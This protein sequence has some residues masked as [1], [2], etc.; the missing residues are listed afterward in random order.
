[1]AEE[2]AAGGQPVEGRSGGPCALGVC[3]PACGSR[4]AGRLE[5]IMRCLQKSC[6]QAIAAALVCLL[7]GT[8]QAQVSTATIQGK[9][10]SDGAPAP[11]D[12]PAV[13]VK[14]EPAFAYKTGTLQDGSS[15]MTGL[16][17]GGYET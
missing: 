1:M 7:A 3:S 17:P 10:T 13:A 15:A 8:A 4:T 11:A 12:L 9:V 14:Q 6:R 5:A 2:R 16:R